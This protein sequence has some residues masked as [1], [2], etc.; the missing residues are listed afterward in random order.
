MDLLVVHAFDIPPQAWRNGAGQ[1]RE[2]L[3]W[4]DASSWQL[5]ISLADVTQG[6]PFSAYPGV[7]RWIAVVEGAGIELDLAGQAHR[8]DPRSEPLRFDGAEAVQCRLLDGPTRDLNLMSASGHGRMLPAQSGAAWTSAM[9]QRGIF[10]RMPGVWKGEA[11]GGLVDLPA[12]ALLWCAAAADARFV[13]E[14]HDGAAVNP[15]LWLG[16]APGRAGAGLR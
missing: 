5:R 14:A 3:A 11:H 9:P 4:P 8:L 16:F 13:F 12:N 7:E 2:L 15:A 6:G 1:T 10:T